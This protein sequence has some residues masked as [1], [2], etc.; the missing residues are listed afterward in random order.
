MPDIVRLFCYVMLRCIYMHPA[1]S[2]TTVETTNSFWLGSCLPRRVAKDEYPFQR[3]RCPLYDAF[4]WNE[5]WR[6]LLFVLLAART[7]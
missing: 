3:E 2:P 4:D 5:P 7:Q 1:F 6:A